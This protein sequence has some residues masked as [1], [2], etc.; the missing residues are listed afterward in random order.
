MW[1]KTDIKRGTA[2]SAKTVGSIKKSAPFLLPVA[3]I[4]L[5][6]AGIV[7]VTYGPQA[8]L[9]ASQTPT[10]K[11]ETLYDS[12]LT[13]EADDY[14]IMSFVIPA[15]RTVEGSFLV[16]KGTKELKAF[17]VI[18]KHNYEDH[19]VGGRGTI[20]YIVYVERPTKYSF[21]F[22]TNASDKYYFIFS[23]RHFYSDKDVKFTLSTYWTETQVQYQTQYNYIPFYAGIAS[24]AIGFI[25]VIAGC[26]I[27]LR[28][29]FRLMAKKCPKC[30]VENPRDSEFC[31]AC[32]AKFEKPKFPRKLLLLVVPIL[33]ILLVAGVVYAYEESQIATRVKTVS[34]RLPLTFETVKIPN[35]DLDAFFYVNTG[36]AF[37]YIVSFS[38]VSFHIEVVSIAFWTVPSD[39]TEV[40]G[41]SIGF[42]SS[43]IASRIA[44]YIPDEEGLWK[45]VVGSNLFLVYGKGTGA[46]T[47]KDCIQ[48]GDFVEFKSRLPQIY[49]T[50]SQ[51]PSTAT[52][53]PIAIGFI[54]PTQNLENYLVAST[55]DQSVKD[56]L[57][58]LKMAKIEHAI[59]CVYLQKD[60]KLTEF[61]YSE[62]AKLSALVIA[63]SSYPGFVL[64]TFLSAG[65][66]KTF[67]KTE[68]DGKSAYYTEINEMQIF[69]GSRGFF[70]GYIIVA[71]APD[72][73]KAENLLKFTLS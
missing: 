56:Y 53:K 28:S 20:Q 26:A 67:T 35:T 15:N 50:M 16:G 21:S 55:G 32:G 3:G 38:P 69:L 52:D 9:T 25:L 27:F 1:G 29:K 63:K 73:M 36:E 24:A 40:L 14:K 11:A 49:R 7:L 2:I 47:L 59:I 51:L 33:G 5:L 66:L 13:V 19:W 4:I 42:T 48:R 46:S 6:L 71:I 54:K 60:V 39:T 10:K 72:K 61:S 65:I 57:N 31:Q 23:N 45:E 18:D 8:V 64:Q 43:S 34:E 41:L 17:Y 62:I 37:R 58:Y 70:E 12:M 22:K 44:R 68:V 30:G